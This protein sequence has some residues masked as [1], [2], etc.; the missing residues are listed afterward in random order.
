[1]A[2]S[3][4]TPAKKVSKVAKIAALLKRP[5]GVTRGQVLKATGWKA[6]SMQQQARAAGLKLRVESPKGKPYIYRAA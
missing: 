2:K 1:M 3:K 5:I 6:V 4:K